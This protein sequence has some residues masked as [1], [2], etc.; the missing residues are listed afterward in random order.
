[1][2]VVNKQFEFLEV[3]KI[4]LMLT[5]SMMRFISLL[6]LCLCDV[7]SHVVIL[8]RFV[9]L[10]WYPVMRVLLFVCEVSRLRECDGDSNDGVD[11]GKVWV[12]S[13]EPQLRVHYNLEYV[14]NISFRIIL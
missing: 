5:Y 3:F 1:M 14:A 9:R 4:L 13:V 8:D 2:C 12:S 11:P 10:F 6:L 7:C